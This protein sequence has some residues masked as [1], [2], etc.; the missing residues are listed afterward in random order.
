MSWFLTAVTDSSSFW[1]FSPHMP[2][3][4]AMVASNI[5]CILLPLTSP[6]LCSGLVPAIPL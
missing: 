5:A 4:V 6:V 2:H 1:A 3:L